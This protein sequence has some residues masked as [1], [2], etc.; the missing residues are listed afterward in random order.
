MGSRWLLVYVL[1]S[2]R[3]GIMA[4]VDAVVENLKT[5][6]RPVTTPEEIAQ[7]RTGRSPDF[8]AE[9]AFSFWSEP[10]PAVMKSQEL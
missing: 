5:M 8:V 7:V 2:L 10:E 1:S 4:A 3:R 9:A 6:S